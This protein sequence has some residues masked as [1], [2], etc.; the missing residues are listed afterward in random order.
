[1]N[2][3]LAFVISLNQFIIKC[4]VSQSSLIRNTLKIRKLNPGLIVYFSF[5]L[6]SVLISLMSRVFANGA[7][8]QSSIPG[9]VIPYLIRLC[10]TLSII[11][12]GSSRA[13]K[14]M[15]LSPFLHLG[16]VAIEKGAF[17]SLST[18]VANFT[19]LC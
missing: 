8:N 18:M 10:L 16:V 14:G 11:S 9:Q 4:R 6:L 17:G 19:Y 15:R 12:F 2:E 13:I 5:T 7:R 1:M 3:G